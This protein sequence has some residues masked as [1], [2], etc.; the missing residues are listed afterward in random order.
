MANSFSVTARLSALDKGFSSTLKGASGA[1]DTLKSKV[2]GFTFGMLT[3]AGQQAFSMITSGISGMISE[4]DSSNAAWKTFES[5]LKNIESTGGTLE[6]SIAGIKGELQEFA[7]QTVYSSSDMA[8][9]YAQLAAVGVDNCTQLVKGFGGLA[10]AAE[11]PQQAMKSL[12]TQAVQMAAK[13]KVA[14]EDFKI[15]LEQTPAGI[16]AVAKSMGKSTSQ[17][18]KDVQDGKVKTED[19]LAKIAEVGTND[20]FSKM[21]TEAKTVGM[22]MDG[23]KETIGNKLLPVWGVLTRAGIRAVDALASA[24]DGINANR[25]AQAVLSVVK[26]FNE[27]VTVEEIINRVKNAIKTA[28]IYFYA[29]KESFS[30]V[31]TAVKDALGALHSAFDEMY[32]NMD[33]ELLDT[34]KNIM[35]AIANTI[36]KVATFIKENADAIAKAAPKVLKLVLAFKAMKV[37]NSVVPV[38]SM[39]GNAVGNL[40]KKGLSSLAGKLTKTAKAQDVVGESSG[41]SASEVLKSAGAFALMG[42]AVLAI[43][44]GIALLVQ[45][46]I[47]LSNAGGLAI[48]VMVA[49]VGAVVGLGVGMAVLLKSLAPMSAQLIP[50]AVAFL[51]MGAA[52]LLIAAGFALLAVASISLANAGGPAIAVMVGMIAVIALLAVGAAAL[53]TALTA[54]AVG[55]IAFGAAIVLV[56]VGAL[57]AAAALAVLSLVLPQIVAYG[58]QGAVAIAQLGLG[59]TVFAAGAALAGIACV[60]LGAGLV[61]VAAGLVLVGASILVV[62][63][64]VLLLAAG[65]A[66][67]AAGAVV[68]GAGLMIA[69]S[70][71]TIMA[72]SVP[73]V[74]AGTLALVASFTVLLAMA[75]A[76]S[77]IVL[78]LGAALVVLGVESAASA[79]GMAAFAISITAAAAGMALMAAGVKAVNSNMKSIAKNAK[80]AEKSMKS[81]KKAVK[82]VESGLK[83]IGNMAKDAMNKL[84]SAFDNAASKAQSAG[85]KVGTGFT[86][87]MRAGLASASIVA[88]VAVASTCAVLMS[89]YSRA[90]SAGAY[91][92]VGLANGMQSMLSRVRNVAN[93]LVDQANRA[94]EARAQIGSPS[95]I[96]TQYGKWYGEGYVNGIDSMVKKAWNAAQELVSIPQVATP[97]LAMSYGGEMSGDFDYYRNSEYV[98]EVPLAVDGKEFARATA[99]YTQNELNKQSMRNSRKLGMA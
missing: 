6:N 50:V 73:L 34:F 96:T 24:F 4:I 68:L 15:M 89:G 80:S 39:F 82:T 84:T 38:F 13:P 53:G 74:A 85:Q 42:V 65:V 76:V 10:A 99:S 51:A 70:A 18:I 45:S 20:N 31:G 30:G 27:F 95:K 75:T 62:A 44:A 97:N 86:N 79:I 98:I 49:M 72:V 69:A 23:L 7:Q 3:G 35:D 57:I 59:L 8:Q 28:K 83:A 47:A 88:S 19:L 22:A 36:K 40:A 32:G 43:C 67:L 9:T 64:G 37:I 60:A 94:I 92:G 17:L 48:G 81:M 41:S 12:S 63:A 71:L 55:F 54:G 29:F 93:Q 2:S 91:I 26:K 11:N 77:A 78:V 33:N 21:A 1:V 90:Y 61:V 16:A 46:A 14:W 56:G 52:V 5:N 58:A 66:V 87:G 25:L